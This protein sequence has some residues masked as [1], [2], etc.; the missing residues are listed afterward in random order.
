MLK[1]FMK[2]ILLSNHKRIIFKRCNEH[3]QQFS[4]AYGRNFMTNLTSTFSSN[5]TKKSEIPEA[6]VACEAF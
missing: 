2:L 1:W 5:S 6:K 3:F 4:L